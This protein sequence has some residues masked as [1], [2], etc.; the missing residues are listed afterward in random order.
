M[1]R[2]RRWWTRSGSK[3]DSLQHSRDRAFSRRRRMLAESLE[4]RR[5]LAATVPLVESFEVADLAVL[6]DWTFAS[7]GGGTV[8]L[9]AGSAARTGTTSLRFDTTSSFSNVT[10]EAVLEL[11][12]SAVS[13]ATDLTFDFWMKRLNSSTDQRFFMQVDASGDGGVWTT[14]SPSLQP[15]GNV[16]IHYVYDLD[17]RLAAAGIT[18]DSDVFLRLRQASYFTTHEAIVDDVRVGQ[19]GDLIGPAVDTISPNSMTA[20]PVSS[21]DVTFSEPVD[22][23]TFTAADVV[24]TAADGSTIPLLNDPVDGGSQTTFTLQLDSA[25]T[26][27]GTYRVQIGPDIRDV[28]GNLMNQDRDER[29]GETIGDDTFDGTFEI[30]PSVAQTLPYAQGFEVADLPSLDGFS[31]HPAGDASITLGTSLVNAGD[32]ALRTYGAIAFELVIDLQNQTNATDLVLDYWAAR[33]GR[34]VHAPR[35]TITASNDRTAWTELVTPE[36]PTYGQFQNFFLD[37]DAHLD[38][39]NI[40]RDADVYLRFERRGFINESISF[41]D[42]RIARRDGDGPYVTAVSPAT[43]TPGPLR[44]IDV[45]FNEAIDG[46]RFT[47]DDIQI[48]DIGGNEVLLTGDPVDSGDQTTFRL[49]LT[50]PQSVKSNYRLTI[51]PDVLDVAG[52][53]MNQDRDQINAEASDDQFRGDVIVGPATPQTIPYFQN[54]EADDLASLPGWTFSAD[55]TGMIWLTESNEPYS[56]TRHLAFGQ[57]GSSQQHAMLV[58]D[59]SDQVGATDLALDF[60]AK[61]LFQS[62]FRNAMTVQASGDGNT[63]TQLG[64]TISSD[65]GGYVNYFYDLDQELAAAAIALDGD[66][67]FRFSH[68]G[69]SSSYQ[70]VMDDVR[71][72]NRDAVGPRIS[73]MTPDGST[74]A[75]LSQLQVTFNEA[76]AGATLTASDVTVM[77]PLGEI[78][79]SSDP[80]DTGDAMTFN[81]M[82]D[83]TVS[84][85]GQYHVLIGPDVLDVAGNQMNQDADGANGDADDH[86]I[87]T[88]QF[89][90][91]ATDVYPYFQGFSGTDEVNGNWFFR[92]EPGGR[93]RLVEDG[94][95]QVLRMDN[96]GGGSVNQAILSIDLAGKTGVRLAFN[97]NRRSDSTTAGDTLRLSNDQGQTWH[98]FSMLFSDSNWDSY[99]IDLDAIIAGIG[100]GYTDNFW[101]M[102]QQYGSNSWPN[103]G[104]QYDDFRVTADTTAPSIVSHS[105]SGLLRPPGPMDHFRLTFSEPMDPSTFS[106]ADVKLTRESVDISERLVDI[107]GSGHEFTV[108]FLPSGLGHYEL[109]V[110]PE[111]LDLGAN[112]LDQ[113]GVG[114]TGQIPEDQY[115]ATVDFNDPYRL[116]YRETF[117]SGLPIDPWNFLSYGT[118]QISVIDERLRLEASYQNP[119]DGRNRAILHLDLAGESRAKLNFDAFDRDG[120]TT[121]SPAIGTQGDGSSWG[122][123]VAVS[124][125]GGTTW[126]IVDLLNTSG[127]KSYDLAAFAAA[128]GLSLVDNFQV[129]FQQHDNRTAGGYWEFDNIVV[130]RETLSL[131]TLNATVVEG[132]TDE[133]FVTVKREADADLTSELTVWLLSN[134]T[135]EATVPSTVTIPANALFIDVP[136]TVVDD[137]EIDG[138]QTVG[139][140][141]GADGVGARQIEFT[142]GDNEPETLFVELDRAVINENDGPGA[143]TA[144]VTRNRGLN[145]ELIVS[146]SSSDVSAFTVPDTVTIPV[147]ETSATFS[148]ASH[149]DYLV[150]GTQTANVIVS[151]TAFVSGSTPLRV[152]DDDTAV[153][154][155]IGGFFW[156]TLPDDDYTVTFDV[157]V[158]AG[159][160]WTIDAG[161]SLFFDPGT[162]LNIAGTVLAEGQTDNEIRLTSSAATPASGDWGGIDYNASGQTRSI[163]DHVEIAYATT[164]IDVSFQDLPIITLRDSHV[165]DSAVGGVLLAAGRGD[166]YLRQNVIIE[167]NRIHDNNGY[168][169]HIGSSA[170]ACNQTFGCGT[171]ASPTITENEIHGHQQAGIQVFSSY[172]LGGLYA[173]SGTASPA[174]TKNHIHNNAVG[175]RAGVH[176][177]ESFGSAWTAGF[178]ANNLVVD[179]TGTGILLAQSVDGNQNSQLLNNT[180]VGNGGA[181]ISHDINRFGGVI[182]NNLVAFNQLGVV[183]SAEYTPS[184]GRVGF[185]DV[186]GNDGGNWTNYPSAFGTVTTTNANGTPADAEFNLSL[187]PM[188]ADGTLFEPIDASPVNDAGTDTNA[189]HD[190]YVSAFR[191]VPYDIGAY[192]HDPVNNVVT[193]LLDEDDG[194]LG[195][196]AGN[197]LREVINATNARPGLDVITF[198]PTLIGGTIS[199][200]ATTLPTLTSSTTIEGPGAERLAITGNDQVRIFTVGNSVTVNISGLTLRD[201][202]ASAINNSGNLTV[203]ETV[204]TS[205]VAV[206]GGGIFNAVSGNLTVRRSTISEN[207]VTSNGGG[208]YNSGVASIIDSTINGNAAGNA[209][210][211]IYNNSLQPLAVI[212]STISGNKAFFT[213]G[214]IENRG[215]DL[216][217]RHSTITGNIADADNDGSGGSGGISN[218]GT[219][220]VHNSI[221]AG[222]LRSGLTANDT[223][224]LDPTSTYNLIGDAASAGGLVHGENGNIVGV[225]A[226]LAPLAD[227]GGPTWTHALRNG[228]PA[229]DNGD[230]TQ[231]VD[232]DS[233]W[234]RYDQRGMGYSRNIDGDRSG[235]PT[236]DIGAFETLPPPI[237]ES[238]VIN[239]GHGQRSR[240]DQLAIRLDQP[241][242]LDDEGG[243][244][245]ELI[246]LS[247][248]QRVDVSASVHELNSPSTLLLTFLPGPSVGPGG[249][250]LDGDYQ[251]TMKA[252]MITV[253]AMVLDG[254]GDGTAADHVFGNEATDNF[255]RFFGDT[256]GDRDVDGQDY[257]RFGLTFLKQAGMPGFEPALDSDADGD[258]D[259]QDYGRFGQNFLK[260]I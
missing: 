111:I 1:K 196:G 16:W 189:P 229:I 143:A 244:P 242:R 238:I 231:A 193:T 26:L 62:Y 22:A 2:Y 24:V 112:P 45:T 116:G 256:D 68:E 167:A 10:S 63:W 183:A 239:D 8:D 34:G 103:N 124:D 191:H 75:P 157:Q 228:S 185:N 20:G 160:V 205:G 135:S 210:G 21:I 188:F 29:N 241:V 67:Y 142:V 121:S 23:A 82:L 91:V 88:F 217:I 177:P 186:Y 95:R 215:A 15:V 109:T 144:T 55:G 102:I 225:D 230:N 119:M 190:D 199:L 11:D 40:L 50:T 78:S 120:S 194:G 73:M 170:G 213:G 108:S 98:N 59:L 58:V 233:T 97:E 192:E 180:V 18:L 249:M 149:N 220:I 153:D 152:E 235:T 4:D 168:G 197:S 74:T 141:V 259:G 145:S 155:T 54:L 9:D 72:A 53:A 151:A 204:M 181:G 178:Y 195:L 49:N 169:V 33:G 64:A 80:I 35:L 253:G 46:S 79:V 71:I 234:L 227:N 162:S 90:A 219:T 86:F 41:D 171:T 47:A 257:G 132:T 172:S 136:V 236:V 237:V 69:S 51:G 93:I 38:T 134:D 25:Q 32:N 87:G 7:T 164:G 36:L 248:N 56:P 27:R 139:I 17:Q 113:N 117:A 122:D 70:M 148:I 60:R 61:R 240:V 123:V 156:G 159:E 200:G 105:P 3:S 126:T 203:S 254:N 130:E 173:S 207:T 107:T 211:G 101:I 146:L 94:G 65:F 96:P 128:S 110:G 66:V 154:R 57:N 131:S 163:F 100:I 202:A 216:M 13:T 187:D 246:N 232:A 84:Q 129:M 212:Q 150:D 138:P 5:V 99:D 31:Y 115:V 184:V 226:R 147:G 222:N 30:G 245:F 223:G 174:V 158:P 83:E 221:V 85:A 218:Y 6:T 175:I 114:G 214:G 14:L 37:L 260:R 12:L 255:F 182:R 252:S 206:N 118:G 44:Q 43:T 28:A 137:T 208:I 39:A 198:D 243:S 89:E 161:A 125:N 250:L 19:F 92:S 127:Y 258:V 42:L 165:H 179:N 176:D 251:L 104:R 140:S 209:A 48:L 133:V 77:G 224:P 76:I 247:T 106:L 201:A 166:S 52:N 81:I